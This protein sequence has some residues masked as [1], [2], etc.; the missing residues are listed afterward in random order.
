MT[1]GK[2]GFADVTIDGIIRQHEPQLI[3]A[4]TG[5]ENIWHKQYGQYA[6][7]TAGDR[8]CVYQ[9]ISVKYCCNSS[10]SE[11][12]WKIIPRAC[13]IFTALGQL[14]L[15]TSALKLWQNRNPAAW[16]HPA[17]STLQSAIPETS[18]RE[19]PILP[20]RV[21]VIFRL[22]FVPGGLGLIDF[23]SWVFVPFPHL[24]SQTQVTCSAPVFTFSALPRLSFPWF[25][26][27]S[28]C[29][30]HCYSSFAREY[31]SSDPEISTPPTL[32]LTRRLAI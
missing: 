20:R 3:G 14:L 8:W 6:I 9:P 13:D 12:Q 18:L 29:C 23:A 27:I 19:H 5:K 11:I 25:L 7:A 30:F 4:T 21:S 10:V 31:S 26:S 28:P 24:P 22:K 1:F 2:Q 15:Q 32:M 16:S 17:Y